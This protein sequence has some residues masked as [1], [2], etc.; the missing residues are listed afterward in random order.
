[1]QLSKPLI[2]ADNRAT[3]TRLLHYPAAIATTM[4]KEGPG[5]ASVFKTCHLQTKGLA[6]QR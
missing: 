3:S 2:S 1:M 6:E 5:V 4:L